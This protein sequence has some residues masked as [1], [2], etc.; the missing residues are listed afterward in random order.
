MTA[1]SHV[2]ASARTRAE[3]LAA[4]AAALD[5]PPHF[6]R[7]LDAL[8]DM[9]RDLSWLPA[10]DHELVVVAPDGVDAG[11]RRALDDAERDNPRLRVRV[12]PG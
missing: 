5:F 10:G 7:N 3:L 2:T 11:V 12:T 9:L 4:I 8:Y 1:P 6:G